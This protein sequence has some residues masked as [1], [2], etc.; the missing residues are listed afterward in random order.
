MRDRGGASRLL[1]IARLSFKANRFELMA[2][3]LLAVAAAVAALLVRGELDAVRPSGDCLLAW[4]ASIPTSAD[5]E[6]GIQVWAQINNGHAAM[7]M[8]AMLPIPF[9]VGTLA[10]VP[11]VAREVESGTAPLAWA[12]AGSRRRWLLMRVGP[13][14]VMVAAALALAGGAS[15]LLATTA[16]GPRSTTWRSS[17]GP[18]SWRAASWPWPSGSSR[19][20]S[21]DAR[22]R[23]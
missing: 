2:A 18:P 15:A 20:R 13:I 5:C 19:A 10:G 22:F 16:S 4:I 3:L 12:L 1:T 11:L 21:S 6:S 7:L 8:A 23:P 9:I 14:A 17:T